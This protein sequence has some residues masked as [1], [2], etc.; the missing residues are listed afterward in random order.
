VEGLGQWGASWA[1]G[2]APPG[3]AG[4]QQAI[5]RRVVRRWKGVA[6]PVPFAHNAIV[7][8]DHNH[9]HRRAQLC[10]DAAFVVLKCPTSFLCAHEPKLLTHG[11]AFHRRRRGE[12]HSQQRVARWLHAARGGP[13]KKAP[14]KRGSSHLKQQVSSASCAVRAHPTRQ[15]QRRKAGERL[16]AVLLL[17]RRRKSDPRCC[18]Q[19]PH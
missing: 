15:A 4:S 13:Q 17:S 3:T 12:R 14:P 7:P 10:A 6:L 5:L 11:C 9:A 1:G 18:C 8:V 19:Y 2:N 16:E